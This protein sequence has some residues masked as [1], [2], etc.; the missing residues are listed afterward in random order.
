MWIAPLVLLVSA[1]WQ[2]VATGLIQDGGDDLV[3]V[4]ARPTARAVVV[5]LMDDVSYADLGCSGSPL[6]LTPNID[7]LSSDGVRFSRAYATAATCSPSRAAIL[8]GRYQQRFGHEF[9]PQ[10]KA[11]TG[12]G[13]S[14]GEVT[15]ARRLGW[16]G[17]KTGIIGKWHLGYSKA[18]HP[19]RHGFDEFYGFLSGARSYHAY[20]EGR[21][22]RQNDLNR[23]YNGKEPVEEEFAYLTTELGDRAADFI[24]RHADEP[25]FLFLSFSAVH[26]PFH[27][28]PE[29]AVDLPET[30][31]PERAP[32]LRMLASLDR[33]V[34]H[35]LGALEE[36]SR[37]DDTLVVLLSDNGGRVREG[38]ANWDLLG[39]KGDLLEGGVRVPLVIRWP[40]ALP[41]GV[42]YSE[43]VS[44]LDVVPTALAAAGR[45]LPDALDGV[46]LAPF[47]LS[48]L[49][50]GEHQAPH[51]MLF[52]RQGEQ[53]ALLAGDHK[54]VDR[55]SGPFYRDLSNREG[56]IVVLSR[57]NPEASLQTRIDGLIS[58][59]KLWATGLRSPRWR[60]YTI[61][62]DS[63]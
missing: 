40:E 27:E 4:I 45:K 17:F 36:N 38:I 47:V 55:G 48:S 14:A 19:L 56:G 29:M 32:A 13:L 31:D 25:F 51:P 62:D 44:T 57:A 39:K 18:S 42:E 59:H 24:S 23:L 41:R 33:A 6:G 28:D 7:R 2:P 11:A 22:R 30:V 60:K 43:N 26:S 34:G 15:L 16:E 5:L 49:Q 54:I 21:R 50:E 58:A 37:T 9:N 53:W 35:V 3:Q 1:G 61:T 8:T 52:W 63:D 12:Q 10:H 46:D 20:T